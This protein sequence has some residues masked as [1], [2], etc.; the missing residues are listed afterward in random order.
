MLKTNVV[1]PQATTTVRDPV[2]GMEID[3]DQAYAS[4]SI[5]EEVF[6][7]CS[8]RCVEQF[9]REHLASATTGVADAAGARWIE[10]PVADLNG[11]HGADR[12]SAK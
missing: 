5:A 6:Y 3:P 1:E 2:C 8:K 7:F 12:V 4:R 10:L 11:N 9:D